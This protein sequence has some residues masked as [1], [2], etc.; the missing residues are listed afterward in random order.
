MAAR[1]F[2]T[3]QR[4]LALPAA[5]LEVALSSAADEVSAALGADKTDIFIHRPEQG[6]LVAIGRSE[7]PLSQKQRQLGL[8]ITPLANGGRS[9]KTFQS[10]DT[11]STGRLDEDPDELRGVIEGL[12]VRSMIC[13][14]LDIGGERRGVLGVSWLAPQRVSDDDVRFVTAVARWIG[15]VAHRAEL[16]EQIA[17]SSVAQGRR[18]AAEE[19]MTTLAHDLRNHLSPI[20]V[21]LGLMRRRAERDERERDVRDLDLSLRALGRLSAMVSDMLDVARIEQGLLH[22]DLQ[23]VEIV[24]LVSETATTLSTPEGPIE[25]RAAQPVLAA[26][27][28][29]RIRQSLENLFTNAVRHSPKGAPVVV[30]VERRVLPDASEG[31]RIDVVDQGPGVDAA[32]LPR[33]F[34]RFVTN[35]QG[36]LGMGLYLAKRIATLHG[37]DLTVENNPGAGARFTLL[38]RAVG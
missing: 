1:L 9:V 21:R 6:A 4:L 15:N 7:Q 3:L 34:D 17:T 10:G 13:V 19:L 27:D 22:V 37:G 2:E 16:V 29:D 32:I 25:V 36:G 12:Q 5:N 28:P 35:S 38:L 30:T 20:S 18:A 31:V 11:F 23:P 8:H 26:A 33:L 24:S 14:P